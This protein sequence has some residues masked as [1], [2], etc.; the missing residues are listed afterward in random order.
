MTTK[1]KA[2]I[3]EKRVKLV[4]PSRE[5]RRL[6]RTHRTEKQMSVAVTGIENPDQCRVLV[7]NTSQ[8][9]TIISALHVLHSAG[10]ALHST[11]SSY[12]LNSL[13]GLIESLSAVEAAQPGLEIDTSG[14]PL[15]QPSPPLGQEA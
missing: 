1:I 14:D 11:T 8:L 15:G 12:T 3:A 10:L 7:T 13:F 4:Y 2:K 5:D 6:G 9:K